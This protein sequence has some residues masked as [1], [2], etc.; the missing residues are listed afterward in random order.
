MVRGIAYD[1]EKRKHDELGQRPFSG[2][3]HDD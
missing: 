1:F 3:D 2:D